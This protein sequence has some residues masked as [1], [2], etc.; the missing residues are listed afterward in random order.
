MSSLDYHSSIRFT[1]PETLA[2]LRASEAVT[3][4]AAMVSRL[5]DRTKVSIGETLDRRASA[6]RLI[7][8]ISPSDWDALRAS[9]THRIVDAMTHLGRILD[10]RSNEWMNAP[11]AWE[12]LSFDDD[13]LHS[14][15]TPLP[16]ALRDAKLQLEGLLPSEVDIDALMD[17]IDHVIHQTHGRRKAI[18]R[19][20][21]AALGMDIVGTTML[22]TG[23]I[24]DSVIRSVQNQVRTEL[25]TTDQVLTE[26]V[27]GAICHC[28]CNGN[29]CEED[30][31]GF[32]IDSA[33]VKR[34]DAAEPLTSAIGDV[35]LVR[36][37]NVASL[38]D[39]AIVII[40]GLIEKPHGLRPADLSFPLASGHITPL[41]EYDIEDPLVLL[42]LSDAARLRFYE[43]YDVPEQYRRP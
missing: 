5:F 7:R 36:S 40:G 42:K 16:D 1:S 22:D 9:I 2:L 4:E 13:V 12:L 35:Y 38:G 23:S 3:D 39:H 33:E 41:D 8:D 37:Q 34:V 21:D 15:Y 31:S 6:R 18:E 26:A 32:S 24:P 27:A 20:M 30:H 17:D 19:V 25:Q 28:S 14:S 10:L 29:A 43:A 11:A